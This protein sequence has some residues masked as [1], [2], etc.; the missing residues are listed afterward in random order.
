MVVHGSEVCMMYMHAVLLKA[1]EV[2]AV[3]HIQMHVMLNDH[4]HICAH[5]SQSHINLLLSR[6]IL[7]FVN[8]DVSSTK[9]CLDIFV[10]VKANMG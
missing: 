1:R 4:Q 5:T 6:L 10:F 9:M 7:P 2:W 3:W 8:T